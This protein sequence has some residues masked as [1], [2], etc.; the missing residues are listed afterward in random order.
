MIEY[1]NDDTVLFLDGNFV[2][3]SEAKMNLFGQT[4]HYGYGV[5][6]GIRSYETVNGVKI[7]KPRAHYER[8]QRSCQ[9]MGI[10]FHY[11]VDE[12]IQLTYQVLEKNNLSNAYIR[13]LVFLRTEHGIDFTYRSIA[14][15]HGLGVRTA[16]ELKAKTHL[17]FWLPTPES[18]SGNRRGES[19]RTLCEF[20]FSNHR[21]EKTWF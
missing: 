10:P 13:P 20:D 4:L 2:K 21:S 5:F 19:M 6:E 1:F 15:D 14:D 3:A 17:H 8:L 12:L 11:T 9:L 16:S 7:F 18:K